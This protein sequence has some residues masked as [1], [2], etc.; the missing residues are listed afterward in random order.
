MKILFDDSGEPHSS[1]LISY[2]VAIRQ[3]N[4][5][6]TVH[7]LIESTENS[8][9]FEI[10]SKNAVRFMVVSN[11]NKRG[12]FQGIRLIRGSVHDPKAIVNKIW[13]SVGKLIVELKTQ[14]LDISFR[15]RSRV[16]VE[17]PD[18]VMDKM[19][20]AL[21]KMFN[22]IVPL[23]LGVRT[24]GLTAASKI[25]F[26]AFPEIALP[27]DDYQR[28][29]LFQNIDYLNIILM[30]KAEIVNWEKRNQKRLNCCDPFGFITLPVFYE[31][32]IRGVTGVN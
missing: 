4:Y 20:L 25:L 31:A 18:S 32:A 5:A 29:K 3:L 8:I 6:K 14:L 23:C 11:M 17:A 9:D 1:I 7:K 21:W 30:M 24:L 12:P 2:F 22:Q 13:D 10:F 16:L 15:E 19:A 28:K 27:V 26:S